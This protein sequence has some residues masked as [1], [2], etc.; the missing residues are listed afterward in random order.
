M[1]RLHQRGTTRAEDA[2][3]TP[4]QSHISP[5]ILV[6]EEPLIMLIMSGGTLLPGGTLHPKPSTLNPGPGTGHC[7]FLALHWA[8][9]RDARPDHALVR[10]FPLRRSPAIL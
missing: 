3:G 8:A 9:A 5:I 1:L 2:Q 4:A 10:L 7:A 6:Y